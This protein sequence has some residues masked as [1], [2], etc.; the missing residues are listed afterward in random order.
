MCATLKR[1]AA[2]CIRL[3]LNFAAAGPESTLEMTGAL[4]GIFLK[5]LRAARNRVFFVD[6]L[7]YTPT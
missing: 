6:M 3:D 7:R 1:G 5:K 2:I 4:Q